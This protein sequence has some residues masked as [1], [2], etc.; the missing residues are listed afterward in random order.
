MA[1]QDVQFESLLR[2]LLSP[3][4]NSRQQAEVRAVFIELFIYART[5]SFMIYT[6]T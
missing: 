2:H 5:R 3:D 4:N 1:D 6:E